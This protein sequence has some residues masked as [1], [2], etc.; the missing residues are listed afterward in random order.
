MTGSG[1]GSW[2]GAFVPDPLLKDS[3][4]QVLHLPLLPLALLQTVLPHRL[5]QAVLLG[6]TPRRVKDL[7]LQG[8]VFLQGVELWVLEQGV[9][10]VR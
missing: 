2:G 3:L 5:A 10:R 9:K 7:Q 6:E 4:L 8:E 1:D